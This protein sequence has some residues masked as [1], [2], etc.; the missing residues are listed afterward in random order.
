LFIEEARQEDSA[1]RG[2]P[3]VLAEP[4][5]DAQGPAA[6]QSSPVGA[7]ENGHDNSQ[8]NNN[9]GLFRVNDNKNNKNRSARNRVPISSSGYGPASIGAPFGLDPT[10]EEY[11]AAASETMIGPV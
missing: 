1:D 3:V 10:P 11:A 6:I 2:G 8:G 7:D 5:Q 4:A 9:S